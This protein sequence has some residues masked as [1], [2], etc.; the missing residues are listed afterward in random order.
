M[1]VNHFCFAPFHSF[2]LSLS[3]SF[4]WL[5]FISNLIS[6]DVREHFFYL[7]YSFVV[8]ELGACHSFILL[9]LLLFFLLFSFFSFRFVSFLRFMGFGAAVV[10]VDIADGR[11]GWWCSLWHCWIHTGDSLKSLNII[12]KTGA[13]LWLL[14]TFELMYHLKHHRILSFIYTMHVIGKI[15]FWKIYRNCAA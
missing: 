3:I 1:Y 12:H 8:K 6:W 9:V 14:H 2:F 10:N 4:D 15:S 5:F 7:H 11:L 13:L